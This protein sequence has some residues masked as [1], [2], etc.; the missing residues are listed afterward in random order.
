MKLEY[1]KCSDYYLPNIAM[2]EESWEIDEFAFYVK[3]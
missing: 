2:P 3:L 1:R